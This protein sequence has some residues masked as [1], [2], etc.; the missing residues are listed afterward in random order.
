MLNNRMGQPKHGCLAVKRL[1]NGSRAA[2]FAEKQWL[3]E[4]RKASRI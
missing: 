4:L 2:H 1:R 3:E